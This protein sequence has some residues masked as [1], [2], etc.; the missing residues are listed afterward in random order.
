MCTQVWEMRFARIT[1]ME[2]S[3]QKGEKESEEKSE[4]ERQEGCIRL[5][6]ELRVQ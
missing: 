6:G 4:E 1:E 5:S 3:Q 2:R